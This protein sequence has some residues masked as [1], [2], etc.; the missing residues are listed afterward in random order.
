MFKHLF[1]IRNN[2]DPWGEKR[3]VIDSFQS[4]D[5]DALTAQVVLR[6][7]TGESWQRVPMPGIKGMDLRARFN[8][9]IRGPFII[10]DDEELSAETIEDVI[11]AMTKER[12]SQFMKKAKC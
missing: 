4:W 3:F 11:N 9:D 1:L 12:L 2:F 7:M 10:N 8:T 6:K 5:H